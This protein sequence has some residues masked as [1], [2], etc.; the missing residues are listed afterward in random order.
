MKIVHLPNRD[1]TQFLKMAQEKL[2]LSEERFRL[3]L[4]NSPV[5]VAVQDRDLRYLWAYNQRTA[6][7]E[8]IIGHFDADIFTPAEAA[9]FTSVKRRVLDE[10][11]EINE[12]HWVQRPGGPLYLDIYWEPIRDQ[13]GRVTGVG[14]A[15]VNLTDLK[16]A[17]AALRDNEERMRLALG[18]S[19]TFA[20]EWDP[21]SDRVLRTATCC[22]IVGLPAESACF[23]TGRDFFQRV[24]PED[25]AKFTEQL[26]NLHPAADSY[27]CEYRLLHSD[28]REVHLLE[29]ARAFFDAEG[30]LLRLVG[31][32]T[33]ITERKTMEQALRDNEE[34]Y[35][36]I[37]ENTSEGIWLEDTDGRTT[38]V[39][40]AMARILG[41]TPAEML[42]TYLEHYI[43]PED[44]GEYHRQRSLLQEV[45]VTHYQR[46]LQR[47][48]GRLCWCQVSASP[49]INAEKRCIGT[50]SLKTD[51]T[52]TRLA[53][54]ALRESEARFRTL[55]ESSGD[56][57]ML[58]D[59]NGYLDCNEATLR[60]LGC[61]SRADFIGKHPAQF[62]PP[63]QPDGSDSRVAADAWTA[64][65]FRE[66][67]VR[68][69]WRHCRLDGG[70]FSA[71]V[72]LKRVLLLGKNLLQATVR[73][74]SER[75]AMLEDLARAKEAAEQANQA[76]SLFLANMSHEIR[77]PMNAI[78][79]MTELCLGTHPTQPQR[80][81]LGKIRLA[82][83]ALLHIIDDIL[84]F[85]K[86]EAG[87][88]DIEEEPFSLEEV[89]D[90]LYSLLSTRAQDKGVKL[91]IRID[92]SLATQTFLGDARR[93]G[94]VLVNL[95]GNAI[96]FSSNGEVAVGV[97][98]DAEVNQAVESTS[99]GTAAAQAT[100]HFSVR[101][102]GIGI[103]PEEQARLFQ[104]FSQADASTTRLYGGTGLGLAISQRLV[105]LMG[106][107]VWLDSA[108]GRGSTFHFTIQLTRTDRAP[109]HPQRNMVRL[110]S[111]TLERLRDADILLVEDAE[112]N[113]DVMRGILE[114]AGAR[115]RLAVNGEEALRQV[116]QALPDCVL[117]DCQM[118]VMDGYEAT[119]RLRTRSDCRD[120]PIIALTANTMAGDRERCLAAGMNGFLAKPVN[121]DA[122]YLALLKWLRPRRQVPTSP[123]AALAASAPEVNV[124]PE[125]P[126]IDRD[127]GIAL[128]GGSADFYVS[129]LV[130]FRDHQA[131]E[132]LHRFHAAREAA[133][134]TSATRHAHTLKS[135]ARTLGAA[136]LGDCAALLEEATRL[137]DMDAINTSQTA[138]EQEFDRVLRG[139]AL[140]EGPR[141]DT[142]L[143]G[144]S[145]HALLQLLASQLEEH[146]T[147]ALE[148]VAALE[149][150]LAADDAGQA[151]IAEIKHAI[152]RYD[153]ATARDLIRHLVEN[154]IETSTVG[155]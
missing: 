149:Q 115:V 10:G 77:T 4:R 22:D 44:R 91:A 32:T 131:M 146:D 101:D 97:E 88:L 151:D 111:T 3:A 6:K 49:L 94:Q 84:D 2:R 27:R 129:L 75:L 86:V 105:A 150:A 35:R 153:F 143:P 48:D 87:K 19:H 140:L 141:P 66:G 29:S 13:A 42:G 110:D 55:F 93:L 26:A 21:A 17:E 60:M 138:M 24:H 80:N 64:I 95:T 61:T 124:M 120:L 144:H 142:P 154:E 145:T 90:R 59:G 34:R 114:Q 121:F 100:L 72:L 54:K 62:S 137:V 74:I 18:V 89:C 92:P 16:Q 12:R 133:D 39:N 51:I 76:K 1:Y 56:A 125:L 81:Y 7:S 68:Y 30:H 155:K 38:F 85:S 43:P 104:P 36:L 82:S 112:L 20:F 113:Q 136:A 109:A 99:E 79:G 152:T 5:S 98:L 37:V 116:A 128:T 132:F 65:A 50:V 130:K 57:L 52:N 53:A 102:E 47:K 70:E 58:L 126:G 8:E 41:Y 11:V 127:Q 148:T 31:A 69:E 14:S 45:R 46:R 108:P 106:G 73:D 78:V 139:L 119:R 83:D 71:E 117:M 96:K 33:D 135:T 122:L 107:H 134:W 63:S 123:A 25:R 15:T 40:P 23:D 147:A 9:H 103:T 67:N 28:G 118:P